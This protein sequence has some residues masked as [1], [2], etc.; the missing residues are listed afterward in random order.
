MGSTPK[1]TAITLDIET[2]YA[3]STRLADRADAIHQF[4]LQDLNHDLRL[5]SRCA[6]LLA[7]VRMALGEIAA[8]TED[9]Q[10]RTRIHELLDGC[11]VAEPTVGQY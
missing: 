9:G 4:S 2:L 6:S 11:S 5:A 3:V 8:D 10:T 1:P 7:K